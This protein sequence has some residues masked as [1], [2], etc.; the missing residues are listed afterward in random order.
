MASRQD[1]VLGCYGQ[2]WTA[3]ALGWPGCW[4]LTLGHAAC[5][6]FPPPPQQVF[7]EHLLCVSQGSKVRGQLS[8]PRADPARALG[9]VFPQENC[10]HRPWAHPL[11]APSALGTA[12][13]GSW[14][15]ACRVLCMEPSSGFSG[16]QGGP[17][18]CFWA[19]VPSSVLSLL[20]NTCPWPDLTVF[21]P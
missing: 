11:G 4:G 20:C 7:I 1:S 17:P 15:G 10:V 6:P 16:S 21:E 2:P 5:L 18:I 8:F 12:G 19:A 9:V 14:E 13:W 3:G